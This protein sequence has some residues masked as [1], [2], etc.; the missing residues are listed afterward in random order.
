MDE[1]NLAPIRTIEFEVR[2]LFPLEIGNA[3]AVIRELSKTID[4][5]RN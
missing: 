4:T 5:L 1:L 2:V 3:T